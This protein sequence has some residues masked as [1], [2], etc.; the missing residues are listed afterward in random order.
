MISNELIIGLA[1]VAPVLGIGTA[2]AT[3]GG[4][5]YTGEHRAED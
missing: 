4:S 5:E 3:T 2:A 1:T